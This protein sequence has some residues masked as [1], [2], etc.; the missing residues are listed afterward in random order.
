M[1]HSATESGMPLNTLRLKVVIE[2]L[3]ARLF[4]AKD[5]PWLLKGGY[6]ME[7][8]YRPR[9]R[10][11]K[12]VDLSM[13]TDPEKLLQRL[14]RTQHDLQKAADCD[15]S[16][17]FVFKIGN[18]TSELQGA[19]DGGARFPVHTLLAGRTF[20]R[21][22]VDVG[23][24]DPVLDVPEALVGQDFLGF[25]GISPAQVLAVPRQQQFA[26][27]LHAY[28]LPWSDR[29]NTRT[30][31]LVDLLLFATI[32]PSSLREIRMAVETTFALRNTHAIPGPLPPPPDNWKATFDEMARDA[33]LDITDLSEGFRTVAS[34]WQQCQ[35]EP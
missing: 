17:Y 22:H 14:D 13:K 16:D 31:D 6:A 23:F 3:L 29:P 35:R 20:A 18:P 9:A 12:D 27:K 8:R 30:K 25:A 11:T 10:T 7:L 24:G 33:Q 21:F 19:P 15:F 28:T 5:P 1:K 4:A 26:E 34:F 2:R 32:D